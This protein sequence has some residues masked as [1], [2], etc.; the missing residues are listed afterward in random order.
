MPSQMKDVAQ[1]AGVSVTTVSHVLNKTRHRPVAPETRQRVLDAIR[2]LNYHANANARRL[3]QTHSNLFGLI[4]SEIANPFFPEVILGFEGA[5][6]R[7]GFELL[8]CNTEYDPARSSVAVRKMIENKVRGVAVVTSMLDTALVEQLA[9]EKLPVVL[10]GQGPAKPGTSYIHLD[11]RAGMAQTVE[12]LIGFGHR[13]I[14]FVSGPQNIRSAVRVRDAFTG[15]LGQRGLEPCQIVE[16]NYKVDGGASSVRS[17]FARDIFPTAIV[18]GN[19]LIA[20]GVISA[21]EEVGISVPQD[22]SVV[23]CDDILVAR[24]AR[25][26][27][28]TVAVPR[29]SLGKLAFETL[30]RMQ[31][32]AARPGGVYQLETTLVIRKSTTSRRIKGLAAPAIEHLQVTR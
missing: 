3:A 11:Y 19:D 13:E 28:T 21:L 24:L 7:R 12:H 17:L 9:A 2:D 29:E 22:V 30:Y 26:P 16:S 8:L 23:G 4:L 27:L 18:C 5:A 31:R 14:A 6:V 20:V 1:K 32:T 25:P 15:A 10:F